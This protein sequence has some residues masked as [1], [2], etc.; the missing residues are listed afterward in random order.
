MAHLLRPFVL[1]PDVWGFPGCALL[2]DLLEVYIW[3]V[4]D[5]DQQLMS[6]SPC[7]HNW[8]PSKIEESNIDKLMLKHTDEGGNIFVWLYPKVK[9]SLN[10]DRLQEKVIFWY[11]KLYAHIWNSHSNTPKWL[12]H[13][14]NEACGIS[15]FSRQ[16]KFFW[17]AQLWFIPSEH[18][19]SM[20]YRFE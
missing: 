4:S 14:L 15:T 2:R 7:L 3:A 9:S 8:T 1:L 6:L 20:F 16:F 11:L 5:I 12:H 10:T 19:Q 17:A 18:V 13:W